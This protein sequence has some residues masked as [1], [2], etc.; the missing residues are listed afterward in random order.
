MIKTRLI[1]SMDTCNFSRAGRTDKG[2]SAFTQVRDRLLSVP[3]SLVCLTAHFWEQVISVTVR[4]NMKEGV[5]ILSVG[6]DH[7]KAQ[8]DAADGQA[9]EQKPKAKGGRD[10]RRD[11]EIAYAAVRHRNGAFI[12]KVA[13]HLFDADVD[14]LT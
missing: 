4:S 12:Q 2:V 3:I 10:P 6:T 13:C 9:S 11:E 8:P 1:E 14:E 5:G 7:L